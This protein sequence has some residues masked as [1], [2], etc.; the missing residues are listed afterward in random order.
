M[1]KVFSKAGTRKRPVAKEPPIPKGIK[2]PY[3]SPEMIQ[4][5]I[6]PLEQPIPIDRRKP[7]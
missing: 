2:A 6:P 3:I 1:T 7:R 5:P 4:I